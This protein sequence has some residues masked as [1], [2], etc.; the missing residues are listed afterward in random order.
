MAT[1]GGM[2]LRMVHCVIKY[3]L[4]LRCVQRPNALHYKVVPLFDTAGC[5][6]IDVYRME[7]DSEIN[8]SYPDWYH[9]IKS[10]SHIENKQHP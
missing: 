9:F 10:I 4:R 7:G 6:V 8:S 5:Y 2:K 1:E 3:R